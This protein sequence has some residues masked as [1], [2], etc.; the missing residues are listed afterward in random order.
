MKLDKKYNKTD[1]YKFA[2]QE[3]VGLLVLNDIYNSG[4]T[5]RAALIKKAKQR[6]DKMKKY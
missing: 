4:I 2:L 5:C 1:L 3:A 6:C